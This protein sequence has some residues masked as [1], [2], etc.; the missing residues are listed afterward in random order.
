MMFNVGELFLSDTWPDPGK[1]W[2][3]LTSI[4]VSESWGHSWDQPI[5]LVSEMVPKAS[6]RTQA[7]VS[8]TLQA[9]DGAGSFRRNFELLFSLTSL[10][11]P[12]FKRKAAF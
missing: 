5:S 2:R 6:L 11:W 4:D 10:K 8:K 7:K 3:P 12:A 9:E 1:Y